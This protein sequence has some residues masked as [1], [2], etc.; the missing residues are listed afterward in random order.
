MVITTSIFIKNADKNYF[1]N[2]KTFNLHEKERSTR[3]LTYSTQSD[4]TRIHKYN[5]QNSGK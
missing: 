2:I 1:L 4:Y 5:I 3:P